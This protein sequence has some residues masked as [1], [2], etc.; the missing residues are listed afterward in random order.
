ME[1]GG[2]Q[3]DDWSYSQE[4]NG[5]VWRQGDDSLLR[6]ILIKIVVDPSFSFNTIYLY[7]NQ[8]THSYADE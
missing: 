5:T 4:T 7:L 8:C 2:S 3:N 1:I 6:Y